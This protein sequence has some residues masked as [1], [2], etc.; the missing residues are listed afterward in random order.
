MLK[1]PH[2]QR[3]KLL[4]TDSNR[5]RMGGQ[6]REDD[7][8][9]GCRTE[10]RED[11]HRRIRS[12]L[13]IAPLSFSAWVFVCVSVSVITWNSHRFARALSLVSETL[14]AYRAPKQGSAVRLCHS[15]ASHTLP[16]ARPTSYRP[17]WLPVD[18]AAQNHYSCGID[19]TFTLRGPVY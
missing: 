17:Q 6:H 11:P 5:T 18:Y 1:I 2:C 19:W 8:I 16:T 13:Q 15:R 3:T 9:N 4:P 14:E 12:Y 10:K 7:M